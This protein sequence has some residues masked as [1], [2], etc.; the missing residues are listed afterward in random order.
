MEAFMIKTGFYRMYVQN[1]ASVESGSS[2]ASYSALI[3]PVLLLQQ[4]GPPWHSNC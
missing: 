2:R 4:S 3:A 1:V